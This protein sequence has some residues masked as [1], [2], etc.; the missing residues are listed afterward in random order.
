MNSNNDDNT[1]NDRDDSEPYEPRTWEEFRAEFPVDERAVKHYGRIGV[2]DQTILK[3]IHTY[4]ADEV[5]VQQA[6]GVMH[7]DDYVSIP[8]YGD[9]MFIARTG[10][11]IATIGGHL[12]LH[13]IFPDTSHL[14]LAEPGANETSNI[15]DD[16]TFTFAIPDADQ[17][18][19]WRASPFRRDPRFAPAFERLARM[20]DAIHQIIRHRPIDHR[21][22]ATGHMRLP[23]PHDTLIIL[24][25]E[26]YLANV[27]IVIASLGG[28]LELRA[29]FPDKTH[30]LL[31]EPGPAHYKPD[32]R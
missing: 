4:G 17:A 18:I 23:S 7:E 10:K 32:Q 21:I 13:A 9:G 19:G 5:T 26:Q 20:E 15:P 6:A 8:D 1:T 29:V 25:N 30:I 31:I 14:L 3:L 12:E 11:A 16:E 2:M 24:D 28:E 27:G 22:L